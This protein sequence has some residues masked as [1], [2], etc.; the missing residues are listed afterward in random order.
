MLISINLNKLVLVKW[1]KH[2]R[3]S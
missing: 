1:T 3:R 2:T